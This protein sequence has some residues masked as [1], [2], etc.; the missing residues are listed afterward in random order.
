MRIGHMN[1]RGL[2][3]LIKQ[4]LLCG[5]KI[6]KLDFNW[7]CIFWKTKQSKIQYGCSSHQW[8]FGLHSLKSLHS[9]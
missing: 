1:E 8:Y 3:E 4:Y 7:Y 6:K 2:K 9:P 5:K